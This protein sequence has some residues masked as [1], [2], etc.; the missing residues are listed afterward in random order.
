M[1]RAIC[2]ECHSVID[3]D[4]GIL[5]SDNVFCKACQS[6]TNGDDLIIKDADDN[7]QFS[8]QVRELKR[9]DEKYS[10]PGFKYPASQKV[11]IRNLSQ[12][13]FP[14]APPIR[15]ATMDKALHIGILEI[16]NSALRT[17]LLSKRISSITIWIIY[18]ILQC[19][20][21]IN[22]FSLT[23]TVIG[24]AILILIFIVLFFST[25]FQYDYIFVKK[26]SLTFKRGVTYKNAKTIYQCPRTPNLTIQT[27]KDYIVERNSGRKHH[28]HYDIP[29]YSVTVIDPKTNKEYTIIDKY[30]KTNAVMD[31]FDEGKAIKEMIETLLNADLR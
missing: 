13:K 18:F 27:S 5:S 25:R 19:L 21:L 8:P 6:R 16:S 29:V 2:P 30:W 4:S 24:A 17:K 31:S 10:Y 11:K 9:L 1:Q 28:N 15:W 7:R 20:V 14:G 12:L 23:V 3:I 22:L 26:D